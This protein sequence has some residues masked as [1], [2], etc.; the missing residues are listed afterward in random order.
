MLLNLKEW[1]ENNKVM[2]TW[3]EAHV[4]IWKLNKNFGCLNGNELRGFAKNATKIA[5]WLE[6]KN[7]SNEALKEMHAFTS[8]LKLWTSIKSFLKRM[9]IKEGDKE[10]YEKELETFV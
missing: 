2:G 3:R 4:L 7:I 5:E 9:V 10:K 8:A 6:Q 1:K